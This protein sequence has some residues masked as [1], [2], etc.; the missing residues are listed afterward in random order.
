MHYLLGT[1]KRT[2]KKLDYALLHWIKIETEMCHGTSLIKEWKI[3]I[4]F[5][6]LQYHYLFVNNFKEHKF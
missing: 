5:Q 4:A 2:R 1:H 3:A 6:H